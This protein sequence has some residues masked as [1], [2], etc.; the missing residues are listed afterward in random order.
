MFV[1]WNKLSIVTA[2]CAINFKKVT[3]VSKCLSGVH[4]CHGTR[5]NCVVSPYPGH[6]AYQYSSYLVRALLQIG[7]CEIAA[8]DPDSHA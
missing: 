8:V 4:K 6:L 3:A 1:G 7:S 5:A 2:F